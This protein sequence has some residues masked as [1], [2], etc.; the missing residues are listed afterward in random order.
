LSL[1]TTRLWII[2]PQLY[3]GGLSTPQQLKIVSEAGS[4]CLT[5]SNYCPVATY[6][7][8]QPP[9][10]LTVLFFSF[11]LLLLLLLNNLRLLLREP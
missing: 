9:T 3:Q 1:T 10:F 5:H 2:A 8:P 6:T 7:Q 4:K 11:L